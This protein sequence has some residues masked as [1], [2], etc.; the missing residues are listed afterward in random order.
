MNSND[1]TECLYALSVL[2]SMFIAGLIDTRVYES[3]IKKARVRF[4]KN[5]LAV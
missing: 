1:S 4:N 5:S 3:A 2:T